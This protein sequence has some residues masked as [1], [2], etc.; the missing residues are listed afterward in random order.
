[1]YDFA[2]IGLDKSIDKFKF[3]AHT[4]DTETWTSSGG[5]HLDI[6]YN[7]IYKTFEKCSTENMIV[8]DAERRFAAFNT[9][10]LTS[11]GEELFMY[12]RK[13]HSTEHQEWYFLKFLKSSDRDII[14]FQTKIEYP[15]Y[16]SKLEDIY[17]D[18][19]LEIVTNIE[20]IVTE[21]KTRLD[22]ILGDDQLYQVLDNQALVHL[23]NSQ[24]T[25]A[26][27]RIKR[28]QRLAVPMYYRD[29]IQ[30]LLPIRINKKII[31]LVVQKIGNVYR[32]NTI[33][34]KEMAYKNARLLM[35]PEISWIMP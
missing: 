32:A 15:S 30:F 12:F 13:N 24:I 20:H 14:N 10:L 31:P 11:L 35:R 26:Q 9:G 25:V 5:E 22:S 27:L 34:T 21:N 28:N 19:D 3:L 8:F 29:E 7:Y 1:M 18:P 23:F 33:L 4:A 16:V 17:F 6:L 2:F